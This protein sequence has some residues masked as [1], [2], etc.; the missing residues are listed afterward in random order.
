M[1]IQIC[2]AAVDFDS[3]V[4]SYTLQVSVTDGTNSQT[5]TVK[6]TLTA[7]NEA[8]PSFASNPTQPVSESEAAGF[9]VVTYVATDAD[10]S[11]HDVTT[12]AISAGLVVIS[13]CYSVFEKV[14]FFSR[15]VGRGMKKW[16]GKGRE[17]VL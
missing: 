15:R 3:A 10:F 17:I 12:Y 5:V 16:E 1:I 6:V 9:A 13:E 4:Q 11:P 14:P 7:V 2:T 8:T